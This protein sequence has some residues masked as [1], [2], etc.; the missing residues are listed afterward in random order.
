[1]ISDPV[2]IIGVG[3]VGSALADRLA[4]AGRSVVGFDVCGVGNRKVIALADAVEGVAR[5]D[6]V[7][8]SLPDGKVVSEVLSA[9]PLREGQLIIDT[10]T[11]KPEDA[12]AHGRVLDSAGGNYIEA[13]VAGSSELLAKGQASLFLGGDEE[14][15]ARAG[16]LL[17]ALSMKRFHVGE[18]G[19]AS[20]F[21]LM[22]N[23]V[24]GLHRA[25]LAEALAFGKSQGIARTD[26]LAVLR[27][28]PAYSGVMETKGERMATRN[29]QSP[30]A[31]L[32]QHLKDVRL[33]LE[34]GGFLP[35]SE[36]HRQ[37][38]EAAE[39]LGFGDSDNSA[40][41]EAYQNG[42]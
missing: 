15:I 22:F 14:V 24:L 31:R 8:L 18:V 13:T 9:A 3:L 35:L 20:R 6:V 25:V 16:A 40:V 7:L 21:K 38:L 11:G 2:G 23:L 42:D 34:A 4:D 29:Y 10:S 1:M 36:T 30:Q 26:A 41:A 28:T 33:M 27:K 17:D 32:S 39:S 12:I 37:L 19:M 5:C